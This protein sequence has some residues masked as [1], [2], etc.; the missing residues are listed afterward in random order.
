MCFIDA[1][2]KAYLGISSQ[3]G[4][5]AST[6]HYLTLQTITGLKVEFPAF[7][8]VPIFLDTFLNWLYS[9]LSKNFM[10]SAGKCAE[11]LEPIML[12]TS[13]EMHR[14]L[15]LHCHSTVLEI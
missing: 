12:D 10:I 5:Y 15:K 2:K 9:Y 1:C 13:Q 7:H 14:T 3:L 11:N 4:G 6:E 8:T